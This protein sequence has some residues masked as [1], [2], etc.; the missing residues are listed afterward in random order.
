MEFIGWYGKRAEA[1]WPPGERTCFSTFL[2]AAADWKSA[3]LPADTS[4]FELL[5]PRANLVLDFTISAKIAG[6]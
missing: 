1:R 3:A 6:M 5:L 4:N 2:I